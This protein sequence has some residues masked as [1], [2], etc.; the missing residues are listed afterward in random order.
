[1]AKYIEL[2]AAINEFDN[3]SQFYDAEWGNKRFAPDDVEEI[4]R[5]V[6]AA[7]VA[8][9][10]H[11]KWIE[12]EDGDC[13]CSLCGCYHHAWEAH[14]YYCQHCGAR[15]DGKENNNGKD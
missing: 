4:I 3:Q 8:P 7:D 9:V 5:S 11:G 15:M 12:L 10:V 13:K 14:G 2:E 6:P 1:M